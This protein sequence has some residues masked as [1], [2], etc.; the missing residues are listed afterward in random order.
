MESMDRIK[1]ALVVGGSSDIGQELI[2]IFL[3]NGY[4]V[5]ST[6]RSK[7]IKTTSSVTN[8]P[9]IHLDTFEGLER[10]KEIALDTNPSCVAYLPGQI[11]HLSFQE[12]TPKSLSSTFMCNVFGYWVCVQACAKGMKERQFGRFCSVSSI[13]SKFGGGQNRFS[14]TTSKKLLEFFPREM[15][16]LG[17]YNVFVNNVVCGVTDTKML[18]QKPEGKHKRA[19]L[20]PVKRLAKPREIAHEIFVLCSENNTYRHCTNTT[21]SG[22]E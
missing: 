7:A 16:E 17:Q 19:S 21:V 1:R 9:A 4:T 6:S 5:T 12:L 10:H 13:G 22:G 14:Y 11:D 15:K 18:D 20:I 2:K 3:D 8:I